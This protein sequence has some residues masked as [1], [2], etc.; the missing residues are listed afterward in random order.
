ME[1]KNEI[2]I[3]EDKLAGTNG[4]RTLRR[5]A[6]PRTHRFSRRQNRQKTKPKEAKRVMSSYTISETLNPRRVFISR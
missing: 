5:N 4:F 3:F 1:K 6:R 2:K